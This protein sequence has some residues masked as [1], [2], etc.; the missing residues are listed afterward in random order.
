MIGRELR[1]RIVEAYK[2]GRSGTYEETAALFGVS[3]ASVSRPRLDRE[4][5]SVDPLP[6]G[7]NNPRAIDLDW[8][9]EHAEAHP[10]ARLIDRIED[11]EAESGRVRWVPVPV[12]GP[13]ARCRSPSTSTHVFRQNDGLRIA[14]ASRRAR[15]RA[16]ARSRFVAT[17]HPKDECDRLHCAQHDTGVR[18]PFGPAVSAEQ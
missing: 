16:R 1:E 5:G 6:I 11:W 13:V 4:T 8:L 3:R 10:D 18:A 15:A 9:R 2:A 17:A 12:P 7:G 14:M